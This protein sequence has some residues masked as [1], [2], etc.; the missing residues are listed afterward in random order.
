ME[1]FL[2]SLQNIQKIK[3]MHASSRLY[4]LTEQVTVNSCVYIQKSWKQIFQGS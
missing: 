2:M 1:M 4:P 3:N